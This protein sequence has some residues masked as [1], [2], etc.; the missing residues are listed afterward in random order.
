MRTHCVPSELI[1][2]KCNLNCSRNRVTISYS[3]KWSAVNVH[4]VLCSI[5][6][7]KGQKKNTSIKSVHQNSL[8]GLQN[9]GQSRHGDLQVL[10]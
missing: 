6:R 5:E 2:K 8:L 3:K 1:A 7:K 4:T 10:V 9:L